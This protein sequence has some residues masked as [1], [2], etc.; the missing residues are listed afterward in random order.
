MRGEPHV[1]TLARSLEVS[2]AERG[3][4]VLDGD[5]LHS[6]TAHVAAGPVIDVLLPE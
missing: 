5:L 6:R 4:Y 1:D 3:A 2:F